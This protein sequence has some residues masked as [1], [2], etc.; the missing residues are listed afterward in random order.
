VQVT[1]LGNGLPESDFTATLSILSENGAVQFVDLLDGVGQATI[2]NNEEASLVVVNTPE[3]LY[4]YNPADVG[5]RESSEP[6]S[7]G[8]HYAVEIS[9]AAPVH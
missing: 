8:L 1:N 7:I 2:K 5:P 6:A 9:G 3:T 4:M